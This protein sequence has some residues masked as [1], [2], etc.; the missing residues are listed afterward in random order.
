MKMT[1]TPWTWYKHLDD[2][3]MLFWVAPNQYQYSYWFDVYTCVTRVSQMNGDDQYMVITR[4]IPDRFRFLIVEYY[5]ANHQEVTDAFRGECI[6]NRP[7]FTKYLLNTENAKADAFR[8]YI[9][10]GK[11]EY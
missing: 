10:T 6:E 1:F 2:H 3:N 8:E 9:K 7:K 4:A 11:W 5:E